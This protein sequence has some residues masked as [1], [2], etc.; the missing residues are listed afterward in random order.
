MAEDS[1][2]EVRRHWQLYV[3]SNKL[4]IPKKKSLRKSIT[5]CMQTTRAKYGSG[6]NLRSSY[7][8][9]LFLP[10]LHEECAKTHGEFW[11]TGTL[12]GD[13]SGLPHVNPT[14]VYSLSGDSFNVHYGMDPLCAFHLSSVV[15]NNPPHI[16]TKDF[17]EAAKDQFRS[18]L[19]SFKTRVSAG[20][21]ANLTVRF[22]VGESLAFCRALHVYKD[23]KKTKTGV[24]INPWGGSFIDLNPTD[25]SNAS[26]TPV[27]F[28]V[29]DT[30]NL[31]DHTG[32]LNV[33][34]LTIPLLQKKPWSV[35]YTNTLK[36]IESTR[37]AS[38]N[39]SALA[40]LARFD[41]PSLSLLLGIAPIA[42]LSH[43]TVN[44]DEHCAMHLNQFQ[45]IIAWKFPTPLMPGTALSLPGLGFKEYVLSFDAEKLGAFFF[46]VYQKLFIVENTADCLMNLFHMILG[47]STMH[48][49]RAT[50]ALFLAFVRRR[51]EVDWS[52]AVNHFLKLVV[53]DRR[54]LMGPHNYQDLL[55]Y[56]HL[57]GAYDD[58]DSFHR[59]L[60]ICQGGSLYDAYFSGWDDIPPY[61]CVVLTV[62]R[63]SIRPLERM[64]PSKIKVPMLHCLT[65]Y[66]GGRLSNIHSVVQPIFGRTSVYEVSGSREPRV[67]I[68]EDKTG[69]DGDS[70]LIVTF[71][72]ASWILLSGPPESIKIGLHFRITPSTVRDIKPVLGP[73]LEI[74]ST[75]LAN[76]TNVQVVRQ[77][78][79]NPGELETLRSLFHLPKSPS[80]KDNTR[81]KVSVG[82]NG[83]K[84][85]TLTVRKEIIGETA[86]RSL[87]SG[88]V[89]RTTP[90]TDYSVLVAFDGFEE[91]AVFPFPIC[92]GRV[93]IRIAR[94]SSYIEIEAPIRPHFKD[95]LDVSL[96]MFPVACQAG[97]INLLNIPYV[98]LDRLPALRLPMAK[99]LTRAMQ[100]HVMSSL[101][102]YERKVIDFSEQVVP[103]PFI[104]LKRS[105]AGMVLEYSDLQERGVGEQ[106]FGLC[107]PGLGPF[108]CYALLFINEAVI[109]VGSHSIVLD[110]CVVSTY[111]CL[112]LSD[113]QKMRVLLHGMNQAMVLTSKAEAYAWFSLL[114]VLAER[115]R[116][117]KHLPSCEY[118]KMDNPPMPNPSRPLCSCGK[119]KNLGAFGKKDEYKL[120]HG[121]AT[122]IAINPLFDFSYTQYQ[123]LLPE[124]LAG[125]SS[126][127]AGI[128]LP[129][130]NSFG[131][132]PQSSVPPTNVQDGCENCHEDPGKA[133]QAGLS[134]CSACK[135]ARYCSR[136]CQKAHW[137]VHKKYCIKA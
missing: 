75:S 65:T 44:S 28:N 13:A 42:H 86:V 48:D 17:V 73:M 46:Q 10:A 89:V 30:S 80:S 7:S 16:S 96:N 99:D 81:Q 69:W 118:R 35:L 66:R 58:M 100:I 137:K 51:V 84:F 101:T 21:D 126:K 68:N 104:D 106:V 94:K 111:E 127:P 38:M 39:M 24:Y 113:S 27:S 40:E 95:S 57:Y 23:L 122:R 77:R 114:P 91:I 125:L 119:G 134:F 82:V 129:Q 112:L 116:M 32:L 53:A 128:K 41:I 4:S 90:V 131:A 107:Y 110:A 103:G 43:F 78:P 60:V 8:A 19:S 54:L 123:T 1:L 33:L 97:N 6:M 130:S 108:G 61:V 20:T 18:W 133:G 15:A 9:G 79:N 56:L 105:I 136:E 102:A 52:K 11:S 87:S 76:A 47:Q 26:M 64:D 31:T 5:D 88:A 14:F 124:L 37:L 117:W 135:K 72:M 67:I 70:S 109:D 92:A 98:N 55:C 34:L 85:I 50:F 121:D 62:P 59:S 29:I 45:D 71:Y 120:L 22:F 74:Y 2:V 83:A 36:L 49:S 115:C 25:Y 132:R 12:E 63:S 93:K 3:D